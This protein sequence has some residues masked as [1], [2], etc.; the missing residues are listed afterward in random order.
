MVQEG[1]HRSRRR[2]FNP[3]GDFLSSSDSFTE[4]EPLAQLRSH[5]SLQKA[6]LVLAAYA[7]IK[8][9]GLLLMLVSPGDAGDRT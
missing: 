8:H 9:P 4:Q 7:K 5:H 6:S 3:R 2:T 1:G